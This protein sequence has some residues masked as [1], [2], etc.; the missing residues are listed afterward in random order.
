MPKRNVFSRNQLATY[1]EKEL[2]YCEEKLFD[3]PQLKDYYSGKADGL[4][5]ALQLLEDKV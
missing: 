4:R 1:Y 3:F 5:I 2:K